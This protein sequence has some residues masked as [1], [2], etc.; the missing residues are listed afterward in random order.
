MTQSNVAHRSE[1][2]TDRDSYEAIK[3]DG[4]D[5]RLEVRDRAFGYLLAYASVRGAEVLRVSAD[6]R[7]GRQG[8][9]WHNVSLPE[10]DGGDESGTLRVFGK[11]QEWETTPLPRQAVFTVRQHYKLLNDP[12]AEW[13]V[14][15]TEHAPSKYRAAREALPAHGLS[16]S[17][18]ET[19]LD[20]M[21]IDHVFREYNIAPPAITVNGMRTHVKQLCEQAEIHID[22]EYL[23]LHGARRGLGDTVFRV[24]RGEAQDLLRHRLPQ[25]TK[26]AYSHLKSGR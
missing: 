23:K 5:A 21:D 4:H 12:P 24:D 20:E 19:L 6:D 10:A 11:A 3:T 13:P 26:D 16:E 2:V 8:L 25:T 1:L 22:G 15:P 14:F 7:E 18:I 17:E 9:R